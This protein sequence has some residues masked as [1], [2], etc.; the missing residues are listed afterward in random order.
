MLLGASTRRDLGAVARITAA[1]DVGIGEVG[2]SYAQIR[3]T[4]REGLDVV[5]L[6]AFAA[7]RGVAVGEVELLGKLLEPDEDGTTEAFARRLFAI[8]EQLGARRVIAATRTFAALDAAA[9]R[10]ERFSNMAA[11]HGLRLAL[12]FAPWSDVRDLDVAWAI[13][14]GTDRRSGGVVLDTWHFFRGG[15]TPEAVESV[16]A[17]A[18]ACIQLSDGPAPI[19]DV[20]PYEETRRFRRAPGEG[21]FPL[22]DLVRRLDGHGIRAPLSIEVL[23]DE[24]GRLPA[25]AALVKLVR[26]TREVL[27]AARDGRRGSSHP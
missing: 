18:F 9:A 16:P 20:D 2:L 17:D 3:E 7:D 13:I 24:L 8:G 4:R 1:A 15:A 21:I 26:A 25:A 27:A 14:S 11:D 12:E 10:F 5:D 23:S 22:V 19:A 6:A